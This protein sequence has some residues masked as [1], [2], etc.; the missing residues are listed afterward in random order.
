[1]AGR[2]GKMRPF[3]LLENFVRSPARP[4]KYYNTNK[5]KQITNNNKSLSPSISSVGG[6]MKPI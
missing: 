1:L 4:V 2:I 3:L 5:P 6:K